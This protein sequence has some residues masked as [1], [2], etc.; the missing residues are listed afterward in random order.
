MGRSKGADLPVGAKKAGHISAAREAKCAIIVAKLDR[1]RD[2]ALVAG[3]MAQRVPFIVA[4]LGPD[5]DP[6]ML[7]IYAA[8][9]EEERAMVADRTRKALAEK[10]A[11]VILGNR[12]NLPEAN[13]RGASSNRAGADT[14][15]CNVL[16]VIANIRASGTNTNS[17][18]A[19][20]LNARRISTARG[21]D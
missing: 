10:E 12:T 9:V 11:G 7:H 4:E 17:G 1:L 16:P 8:L 3:L 19:A 2:V 20:E 21:G 14:F 13:A 18:I 6:F 5:A 15:G